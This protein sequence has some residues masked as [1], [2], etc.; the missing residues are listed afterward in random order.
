MEGYF[1]NGR[2]ILIALLSGFLI[3]LHVVGLWNAYVSGNLIGADIYSNF[4]SLLSVAIIASLLLVILGKRNGLVG[5]WV[6]I[7]ALIMIQY[8]AHFG[9]YEA[10]FTEGRSVFSYLRGFMFPTAITLLF[11]FPQKLTRWPS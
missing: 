10:D 3:L 8:W 7:T 4:Q 11:L 2:R 9:F 1:A 6:S 5:M